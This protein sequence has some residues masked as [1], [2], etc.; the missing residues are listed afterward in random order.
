MGQNGRQNRLQGAKTL[1]RC[2]IGFIFHHF[3]LRFFVF[4]FGGFFFVKRSK[5]KSRQNEKTKNLS[6][7]WWKIKPIYHLL[8]VFASWIRFWGPFCP[9]IHRFP[10]IPHKFLPIFANFR[11]FL[12]FFE[13]ST[14]RRA[15]TWRIWA[16]LM[17]VLDSARQSTLIK[18]DPICGARP[19]L[20]CRPV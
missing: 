11:H 5:R 10:S 6:G 17:A 13:I 7:K 4:R 8:S 1:R 9:I 18:A 14:P 20:F 3:P 2:Y 19:P 16:K 15:K 12:L